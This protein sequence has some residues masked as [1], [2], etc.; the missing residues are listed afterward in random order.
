MHPLVVSVVFVL[1]KYV[2]LGFS[3]I[4]YYYILGLKFSSDISEFNL[5]VCSR[6]NAL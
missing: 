4:F 1:T 5:H 3:V 6:H 2:L